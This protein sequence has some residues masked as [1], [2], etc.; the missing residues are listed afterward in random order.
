MANRILGYVIILLILTVLSIPLVVFIRKELAPSTNATIRF[1]DVRTVGFLNKQDP[2]RVNGAEVGTVIKIDRDGTTAIVT[3]KITKPIQLYDDYMITAFLKG[4]MGERFVSINPGT[5]T[6][7]PVTFDAELNGTFLAGPSEVIAYV[8]M[9]M[10]LLKD[11]NALVVRLRDGDSAN[12]SFVKQFHAIS[13]KADTLS[14]SINKT[15][16]SLDNLLD[17][18]RDTIKS[19]LGTT[20]K[21]TDTLSIE[22]PLLIEKINKTV[23]VTNDFLL[24]IDL[25]VNKTDTVIASLNAEDNILWKDDLRKLQTSLIEVRR[26]LKDIQTDGLKLPL[27]I[28]LGR[29]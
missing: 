7:A 11:L 14:L 8:T 19:F 23:T 24:K 26:V 28:R 17:K 25:F 27:R 3:I 29:Q 15:A 13:A 2:V 6:H 21:L 18:N 5:L 10:N 22:L 1:N 4:L 9:L 16:L 12:Q 20:M